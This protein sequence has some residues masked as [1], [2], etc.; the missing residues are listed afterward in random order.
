MFKR[1]IQA[2]SAQGPVRASA[3]ET[4]ATHAETS[5]PTISDLPRTES[6][7]DSGTSKLPNFDDIYKRSTFKTNSK[8]AEWH[9]LKIA[10]MLN[11]E[12]LRGLSPAGKH[13]ALMMALEAGGVAVE[14]MLQDAVQRQ[15]VLNDYEESQMRRLQEIEGLKLRE[16]E[17]LNAEMESVCSKYRVRIAAGIE[18]V[19]REH[20]SFREWQERK[21]REQRRIAEAA[22]ACVSGEPVSSSE[23][24]V[25]R[26]LEKNA[27][28]T[29]FRESA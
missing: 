28:T 3:G 21:E 15:R 17:R 10:D 26:L 6:S 12:H 1:M 29:R 14:D 7:P 9:I 2:A 8:M 16:N 22:S 25:T 19:E 13:S 4:P 27:N 23:V 24:S 20:Q 5:T 18:E 11:S